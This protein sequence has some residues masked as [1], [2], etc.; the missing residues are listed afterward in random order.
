LSTS[1]E[2]DRSIERLLQGSFRQ[3]ETGVTEA[4]LD[5]ETIA[6]LS[7]GGLT[8][9][10][11][12]IAERHLADCARC[13]AIVG[14]AARVRTIAREPE[15]EHASRRWLGWFVPLTAAA[16]ALAIW[17]AV[18]RPP[19]GAAPSPQAE[20]R[21]A[22]P[23][24]KVEPATPAPQPPQPVESELQQ[25][26]PRKNDQ[27]ARD[28]AATTLL[29]KD[30]DAQEV[31]RLKERSSPASGAALADRSAA[32]AQPAAH[33]APP[34]AAV[35]TPAR[36]E[37]FEAQA[38]ANAAE[39]ASALSA[40]AAPRWRVADGRLEQLRD[41]A[42]WAPVTTGIG[43]SLTATSIPSP[44]VCWVVGRAGVVLRTTDGQN[45]ARIQFPLTVDLVNV[46]SSGPQA[47]TVTGADGS[48]FSTVNGGTTWERQR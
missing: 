3:P 8:G 6:A 37:A 14:T 43:S 16:A 9:Q 4:C 36:R 11:F 17:V 41:G 39:K 46:Q 22:A 31:D 15:P 48:V 32:P 26:E 5:G 13:Q 33:A 40:Q 23:Q 30:S 34:P 2:R 27:P 47:A 19:E 10:A 38:P 21:D 35:P 7:D 18:P 44:T 20:A 1:G 29:R 42:T 12:E 24:A 28:A 25:A 45:F